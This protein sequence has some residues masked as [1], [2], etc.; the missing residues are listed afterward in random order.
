MSRRTVLSVAAGAVVL[1]GAG[2]F[3]VAHA[4]DRPPSVTHGAARYTAPD[5]HRRGSLTFTADVTAPSGVKKVKVLAWPARSSFAER[6]LTA[7]DM[8]GVESARCEPSGHET[9]R[10]TYTAA[11]TRAEAD[12]SPRGRWYVA[13]L[14]TA[15]DGRTTLDTKAADFT[16]R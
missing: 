6:G 3:A 4:E 9:A 7:D 13:V 14:A 15:E 16:V 2:A 12:S 10:C 1:T 5:G 11:V 8:A